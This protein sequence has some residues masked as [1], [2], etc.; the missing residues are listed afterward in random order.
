MKENKKNHKI[1][2]IAKKYL[3]KKKW[4][5]KF[6]AF[7]VTCNGKINNKEYIDV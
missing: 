5:N 6:H 2:K 7:D 3:K 4:I 1:Q